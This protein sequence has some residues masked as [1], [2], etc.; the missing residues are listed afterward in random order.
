MIGIYNSHIVR[1][2]TG[3]KMDKLFKLKSTGQTSVQSSCWFNNVLCNDYILF[4]NPQMLSEAGMP[5]QGIFF[6]AII[7]SVGTLVMAFYAN[8]PYAQAR[9]WS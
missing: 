6:V 8:L 5:V 1:K 4:V 3:V 7:G 9:V 2:M